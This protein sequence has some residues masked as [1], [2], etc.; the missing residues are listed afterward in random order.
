MHLYL[1]RC[2]A[3]GKCYV[4]I[5]SRS[6]QERFA[7]HLA[8]A[9]QGKK[10]PLLNAIRKY[11]PE[12]FSVREVLSAESWRS[13]CEHEKRLIAMLN[14][15][16]PFGYN[17]TDGGDGVVGLAPELRSLIALKNKGRKH[18]DEVK[19][20]ISETS[21]GRRHTD[22]SRQKLSEAHKGKKL[23]DEHRR[24]LS[25]AHKGKKMKPRSKEHAAKIS[26]GLRRAWARRKGEL[27]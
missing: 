14:T 24:K 16:P 21:K 3:N 20:K 17:I 10:R 12:C 5:T 1:I 13:L 19:R 26:E 9:R 25:E 27:G 11:G 6:V 2:A 23:S 8:E 18:T 22:Q 7:E 4:G 15:K